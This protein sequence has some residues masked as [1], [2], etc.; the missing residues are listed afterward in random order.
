MHKS[1]MM[2]LFEKETGI[3]STRFVTDG[4][5]TFSQIEVWHYDYIHWLEKRAKRN[6][7]IDLAL[8]KRSGQLHETIINQ[9]NYI[10]DVLKRIVIEPDANFSIAD[11]VIPMKKEVPIG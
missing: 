4:I 3:D 2:L 5:H 9:A 6:I 10:E 7:D 11:G 8:L 1:E